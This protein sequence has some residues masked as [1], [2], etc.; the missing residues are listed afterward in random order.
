M[1]ILLAFSSGVYAQAVAGLGAVSGTVHDSTGAV[2]PGATVVVTN[3]AKGILRTMMTTEAGVF[4]AP[5]LLPST[6][7]NLSVML[8]GFK[9]WEAK[10]FELQVGQTLNFAV[11]LEVG[12]ATAEVSVTA[13]APLVEND[14][15]GV[16][17][18]VDQTQIDELPIN[19][20]RVDQFVLST[21]GVTNDGTFGL[22]SIRGAAMGNSFLTDG[23][24]TTNSFYNE[25]AGRTRIATQLSQD[26]V[27]EFQVMAGGFSAEFGRAMAGVINTVTR[28]GGNNVHGTG[29]WFFRNRTLNSADRYANGFNPPEWRHQLGGTVG[30]PIQKDKLFYF[31]NGE[32]VRRNFPALNR[33]INSSFTDAGGNTFLPTACTATAAQCA[34]AEGFIRSQMNVLVPRYVHSAMVF[35]KIDW[36]ASPKN[37]FSFDLN[38]MHWLSPHGIQTG[39]VLTSGN[40]LGNNGNSTVETRYGKA[41]WTS[42]ISPTSLNEFRFGWFK[43]RLSDPASSDIW[44]STGA[45]T[46]T[47]NGTNLGAA[48]A[49]PRTYPSENR[50]QF[51]DN[52]SW[53]IGAHAAKFGIDFQTT[54]DWMNQL[55]RAA[56]EYTFPSLTAFAQDFS[57][58]TAG[59][60]HYSS[61]QQEF[62]NPIHDFYT[63]DINL[64]AQDV[65]KLNRHWTLN[66]GLRYE[67][68]FLP[69]PV[70]SDPNYPQTGRIPN[71]NNNFAPRLSLSFTPNDKTVIRAGYGLFYARVHGNLLDT[72][73]LGN[74]RYQSIVFL[75]ATQAGAPLFPNNLS[76]ATGLPGGS[77]SLEF[78]ANNFYSPYTE[79]GTLAIEH[80]LARDLGLTVSYLWSKGIGLVTQEDLNLGPPAPNPVTYLIKDT[81]GNVVNTFTTPVWISANK[82]D[83]RYSKILQVENGGRSWY[84]GLSVQ[85]VKRMSGGVSAKMAYTWS[86]AIDDGNEQG[87][88]WNIASTFNNATYNGNY[89]YDKG[90]TTLDQRHRMSVAWVWQPTFTSSSSMAA[91]YLVNGWLL[92]GIATLASAQPVTPTVSVSGTGQFPGV[93][94]AY[95]TMNGSGGW[96]R[97]PFLSVGSLDVDQTYRVDARLE[98]ELPFSERFKTKLMFE[99]FNVFNR[100]SNTGVNTQAYSAVGG[101]LT[102]TPN[103]GKGNT[104]GGFPD[105]TNARRAQVALRVVF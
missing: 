51:V 80:Q 26:A 87:A 102:P 90:S 91:R 22:L 13:E 3:E 81:S 10:N 14:K 93:N 68:S 45:L 19:G 86:H 12:G 95:T 62:G 84:N 7:Y 70:V 54:H 52:Y 98:R 97:V 69:Q 88:S 73:W 4:S 55:F 32:I 67:K 42:I 34:A 64:Y 37:T 29:Y 83:P 21:P 43:D 79:Q 36:N 30:G 72:L 1:T 61:F 89:R 20:R 41:S 96:N 100:I 40:A 105:G 17:Q 63:K 44:P 99:G 6:E 23:N 59:P 18:V 56:G 27:Q 92:T 31:F 47:V 101:V 9:T 78:A 39:T 71:N 49:Y 103:L 15:S 94:L 77:V 60:G 5:A 33:I 74:S 82:V 8:Q 57:G 58:N 104:S 76:S 48:N 25:N 65:W 11:S 28:S 75:N 35:G 24:D 85:L 53:T 50:F 38:A 2:V 46:F 66:Y 16:S